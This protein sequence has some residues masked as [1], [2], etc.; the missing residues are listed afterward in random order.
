MTFVS[1]SGWEVGGT[2]WS[3]TS[4]TRATA[5]MMSSLW[6]SATWEISEALL[7]YLRKVMSGP[8]AWEADA[9]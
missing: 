8:A 2:S 9:T 5:P 7:P 6:N 1:G 3:A 4:L